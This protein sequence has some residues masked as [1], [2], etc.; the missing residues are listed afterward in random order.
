MTNADCL[1]LTT[2]FGER[3]RTDDA[4]STLS[5]SSPASAGEMVPA[6]AAL[7]PVGRRG[8]PRLARHRL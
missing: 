8:G 3:H 6:L 4:H 5:T 1:K 7:T 2:Y